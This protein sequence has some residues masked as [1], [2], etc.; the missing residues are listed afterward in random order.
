MIKGGKGGANTKT[1]RIFEQNTPV[2]QML[3]EQNVDLTNFV[4]RQHTGLLW[5]LRDF[6]IEMDD[7]WSKRLYPDEAIIYNGTLY[8]I[9][10]KTQGE[11]GSVDEK[12]QTCDFKLKQYQKIANV[13]NLKV[14]YAYL[15]ADWFKKPPYKDVLDYIKDMNCYYFFDKIPADFFE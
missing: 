1:G 10:K 5:Y 4:F 14:K 2:A 12:I 7:Y 6:G 11:D 8:I 9:E 15:L 13:L 3:K